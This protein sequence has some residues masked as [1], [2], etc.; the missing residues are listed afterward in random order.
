MQNFT[1]NISELDST[2]IIVKSNFVV[3][4]KYQL[5]VP[6]NTLGSFYNRLSE[7][8][9][10]DFEVAKPEEFGSFAAHITNL[11]SQKF[12]IQLLDEKNE[13]AYQKYTDQADVK[14]VNLKPGSYKLRIFVDNNENG[15]WDSSDFTNEMTA[16]DVY[17]FK[18]MGD[19]EVMTKINIRPMWDINEN[20]DL[21]KEEQ[22]AN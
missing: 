15:I 5:T 2:Q 14:F 17:L 4:K 20:W 13:P 21:T 19:K 9:R 11:P 16:E 7:S 12:W 1:A 22:P 3:G 10:F 6:K 8:V 18:K